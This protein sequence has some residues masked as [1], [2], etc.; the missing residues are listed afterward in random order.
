RTEPCGVAL[1]YTVAGCVCEAQGRA[2]ILSLLRKSKEI[3]LEGVDPPFPGLYLGAHRAK[4]GA[5]LL[6]P[7]GCFAAHAGRRGLRG[8]ELIELLFLT[9]DEGLEG[10]RG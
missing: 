3:E 9:I 4:L 6:H 5:R 8:S 7:F 2:K 1:R 10:S